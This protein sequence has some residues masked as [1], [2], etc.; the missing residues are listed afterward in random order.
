MRP[1]RHELLLCA[2]ASQD[3]PGLYHIEVQVKM[4]VP[5]VLVLEE[6]RHIMSSCVL[7]DI[8][9]KIQAMPT[10]LGHISVPA[11]AVHLG[12][13]RGLAQVVGFAVC[14]QLAA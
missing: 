4:W 11:S 6:G 5:C 1:I 2:P 10:C 8:N 14:P 13:R 9:T 7:L 3:A 12:R